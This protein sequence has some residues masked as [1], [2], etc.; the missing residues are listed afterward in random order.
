MNSDKKNIEWLPESD[1]STLNE[2][3]NILNLS[4]KSQENFYEKFWDINN[5]DLI[6]KILK[7]DK[8]YRE[9]K[10]LAKYAVR[11]ISAEKFKNFPPLFNDSE[12]VKIAV[13]AS[14]LNYYY[15]SDTL[16][17]DSKIA[18]A[19]I[20]SLVN[21]WSSFN[22][23]ISFINEKFWEDKKNKEKLEKFYNKILK[24]SESFINKDI[25]NSLFIL[26]RDFPQYIDQLV[27]DKILT[28][29]KNSFIFTKEFY[30]NITLEINQIWENISEKE[31]NIL[32]KNIILN[33]LKIP[34]N[35]PNKYVDF[36]VQ[37]I[38]KNINI[39][40][41]TKKIEEK[42]WEAKSKE[43]QNNKVISEER[44]NSDN[45][46]II[47]ENDLDYW[48]PECSYIYSGGSYHVNVIWD[49]TIDISEQE[50]E[51]FTSVALK[52]FIK[53]YAL[54]YDIW[55]WFLWDKYK[56]DFSTLC[57]NK[58]WFD[59][60]RWEWI[61]Q[62]KSLSI[63]NVIG[64]SIGVPEDA[65]T[66]LSDE[67]KS[68]EE[69]NKIKIPK[70]FNTLADAKMKFWDIKSSGKINWY[71]VMEPWTFSNYSIVEKYMMEHDLIDAKAGGLN[72]SK[73]G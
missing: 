39:K 16:K 23:I 31:K 9:N 37:T 34:N 55:L 57:N 69:N 44:N 26:S 42:T 50:M 49:K 65:N 61:T 64:K 32:I 53:F 5:A 70:C 3:M 22:N 46:D 33:S 8:Q 4:K 30:K 62:G 10:E 28:K 27:G 60:Q 47:L 1:N 6:E 19:M 14:S 13:A 35:I 41:Q 56:N 38:E 18:E 71:E 54:L 7:E 45:Y 15:I 68:W 48:Y 21:E 51:V 43:S 67:N 17:K 73:F 66:Q 11:Y 63:L 25:E 40:K 36:L 72:L 12:I 58:T 24:K 29:Q 20:Q 2:V 59:Y 52:N